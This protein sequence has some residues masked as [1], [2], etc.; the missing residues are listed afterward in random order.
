MATDVGSSPSSWLQLRT[1]RVQ[2][3]CNGDSGFLI[4]MAW[5][6]SSFFE[7]LDPPGSSTMS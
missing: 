7:A 6:K 5:A 2:V 4:N 1:L 3:P